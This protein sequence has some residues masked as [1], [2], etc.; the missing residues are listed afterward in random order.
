MYTWGYIKQSC[1][2]KLD[3]TADQAIEMG[4]LNKFPFYA[5]E[6]ITQITS[7]IKPK[8]TYVKFVAKRRLEVLDYCKRTFELNDVSFLLNQPCDKS[9]LSINQQKALDYYNQFVYVND[10]VK[11]PSD[12]FSWNDNKAYIVT[13][14]NNKE[15]SDAEYN[16]ITG[17]KIMFLTPGEYLIPY[18]ARWIRFTPSMDDNEELDLPDDIVECLPSYIVSQCYKID[19]EQK[20]SIYR[21]EYEMALAR[22]DEND[23]STNKGIVTGGDW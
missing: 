3:M 7:A 17:N 5:N 13:P 19:D 14:W 6:A 4:L 11:M 12:F 16:L 10:I 20:S 2:A 15:A 21:N 8:R 18:N 23:M 22:I 9:D 1:L